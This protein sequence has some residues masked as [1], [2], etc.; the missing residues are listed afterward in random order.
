MAAVVRKL[1]DDLVWDT[2]V[3]TILLDTMDI[4]EKEVMTMICR[5][6]VLQE[7]KQWADEQKEFHHAKALKLNSIINKMEKKDTDGI[8]RLLDHHCEISKNYES[9][10][11]AINITLSYR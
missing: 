10:S 4:I 11:S 6:I 2:R 5:G 1:L 9:V 7:L 3:N 8:C